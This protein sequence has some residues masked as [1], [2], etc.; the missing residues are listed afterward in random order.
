[1]HWFPFQS[2]APKIAKKLKNIK[3]QPFRGGL[4]QSLFNKID[5][6]RKI[7]RKNL[8]FDSKQFTSSAQFVCRPLFGDFWSRALTSEPVRLFELNLAFLRLIL[9][10]KSILLNKL[11]SKM[12]LNGLNLIFF[13]FFKFLCS[14]LC[15]NLIFLRPPTASL[16]WGPF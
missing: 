4:E 14:G 16:Y 3:F 15:R 10:E 11:C 9:R 7:S 6:S 12:P 1:M 8:K 13:Q 5:L 2:S